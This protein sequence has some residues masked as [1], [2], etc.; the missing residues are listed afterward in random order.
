MQFLLQQ[1]VVLQCDCCYIVSISPIYLC[2]LLSSS[3]SPSHCQ[4]TALL[5]QDVE[6]RNNLLRRIYHRVV[7]QPIIGVEGLWRE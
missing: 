4:L 5:R 3:L 7:D 6:K 1:M 2:C